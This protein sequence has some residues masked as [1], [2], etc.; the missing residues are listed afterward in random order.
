MLEKVLHGHWAVSLCPHFHAVGHGW[1]VDFF[2]PKKS[3]FLGDLQWYGG[4]TVLL[5]A[6]L[7]YLE[8]IWIVLKKSSM[9]CVRTFMLY[10]M[11]SLNGNSAKMTLADTSDTGPLEP[12]FFEAW[13]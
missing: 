2:G 8:V 6:G 11:D 13:F 12:L 10:D 1:T 5:P 7:C 9:G 3:R 4:V